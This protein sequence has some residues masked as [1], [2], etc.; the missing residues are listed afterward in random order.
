MDRRL[1]CASPNA[2]NVDG[3]VSKRPRGISP[4]HLTELVFSSANGTNPVN[5][6]ASS[7]ARRGG[8]F[9]VRS[10]VPVQV[11]L[12]REQGSLEV[13]ISVVDLRGGGRAARRPA[14]AKRPPQSPY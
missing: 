4:H 7:S 10:L 13:G 11:V 14:R 1:S 8:T 5:P 12:P 9:R 2:S 6:A 3:G